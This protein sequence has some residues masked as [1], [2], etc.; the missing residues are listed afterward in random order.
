MPNSPVAGTLDTYSHVLPNMQDQAAEVREETLSSST[1]VE[2]PGRGAGG[3]S[4]V[5]I[6]GGLFKG[7]SQYRRSGSNRHGAFAP[8]DFES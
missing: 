6:K 2:A 1:A 5:C 8:P 4:S 7:D 3:P